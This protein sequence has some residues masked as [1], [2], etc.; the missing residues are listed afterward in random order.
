MSAGGAGH[1]FVEAASGRS[2]VDCAAAEYYDALAAVGPFLVSRH[3]FKGL[4]AYDQRIHAGHELGV[5]VR[6]SAARR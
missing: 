1:V 4:A 2:P 6:L 5:T 3:G